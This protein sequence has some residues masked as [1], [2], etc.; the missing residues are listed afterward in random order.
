M[1][2]KCKE[3]LIVM[4][5]FVFGSSVKNSCGEKLEIRHTINLSK[6]HVGKS[7]E[8]MLIYC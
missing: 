5:H 4:N 3:Y 7:R 8:N 6:N 1:E 2:K